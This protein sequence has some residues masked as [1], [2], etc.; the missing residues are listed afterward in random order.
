[1][2]RLSDKVA[3]I[4]GGAG[5]IGRATGL[6]F[7]QEGARV[8]LVDRDGAALEEAVAAI[9]SDSASAAVADVSQG[10]EVAGYVQAA[11]ER[12]GRIDVFFNNAGIE[13]AIKPL[14]EQSEEEFDR[15]IAVNLRGVWLGLKHVIPVML[16]GGG[17]SVIITSSVAG[18]IGSPGLGVYCASKHGVI[19]LMR[20]AALEY[21]QAGLRVN[22]IN[23]GAVA[24]R[25]LRSLEEAAGP[26]GVAQTRERLTAMV[27]Q[28]RYGAP[29]EV[30]DLALF[31]A[32]DES[33]YCNGGI[34]T[35]DGG[36]TAM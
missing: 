18:L 4:T 9:G 21:A 13:G 6:R 14:I 3:V 30:A 12:Y 25:M 8:L 34:Y 19:G 20:T 35:I 31:L 32:S 24:T 2:G 26:E 27:P 7:A 5:G 36:L 17:G 29:E 33:R 1:M 23:P 10:E 22:T 16:R 11:V 28:G 15:V